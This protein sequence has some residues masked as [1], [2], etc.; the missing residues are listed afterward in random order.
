MVRIQ[1][2]DN[3]TLEDSTTKSLGKKIQIT[4]TGNK[5]K[6]G[7][8][9]QV[10]AKDV[11]FDYSIDGECHYF[12]A[13]GKTI[14]EISAETYATTE[15]SLEIMSG[16]GLRSFRDEVNGGDPY[17]NKTVELTSDID[18]FNTEW[19]PIGYTTS[20][21][22]RLYF[23]GT[24][25]GNNHTISNFKITN[26]Y[27]ETDINN[28]KVAV[29]LFGNI[30][31]G[32]NIQNLSV[33]NVTIKLGVG[34]CVTPGVGC[35]IGWITSH[36]TISNCK[37]KNSSIT[38]TKDTGASMVNNAG[39]MIGMVNGADGYTTTV[40]NCEVECNISLTTTNDESWQTVAGGVVGY[41]VAQNTSLTVTKCLYMGRIQIYQTSE[42][43]NQQ[44]DIIV[45]GGIVGAAVG[46]VK[47]KSVQ[48]S[49]GYE[50]VPVGSLKISNCVSVFDENSTVTDRFHVM[51]CVAAIC[52]GRIRFWLGGVWPIL[53]H[54]ARLD[55][56]YTSLDNN[57]YY[58]DNNN[59]CTTGVIKNIDSSKTAGGRGY[60]NDDTFQIG[61]GTVGNGV[62]NATRKT[63]EELG[64]K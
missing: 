44:D 16:D 39:G 11:M 40:T 35:M 36:A 34:Y 12:S 31:Y 48:I 57:N 41:I 26:K 64:I 42:D 51:K 32:A 18:L 8:L 63:K 3:V 1:I 30:G 6:L 13:I 23:A 58:Y 22:F 52:P 38:L 29:G 17:M 25:N 15:A 60:N 45:V 28:G 37:V 55:S 20:G 5:G 53:T 2:T 59:F 47:L 14:N 7:E 19:T 56:T 10:T 9:V 21:N 4:N 24:F 43:T 61:Y 27:Q 50:N 46:D 49:G 62:W 54:E 33:E